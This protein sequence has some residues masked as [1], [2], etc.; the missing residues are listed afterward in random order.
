MLTVKEAIERRR[1]IRQF[2]PDPVPEEALDQILEAARL[3]PSASNRQPWRFQV[4]K[5]PALRQK[6]Y[7]EA[8]FGQR[9]LAQAPVLI[10]C[11]SE[12]HTFLKGHPLSPPGSDLGAESEDWEQLKAF[13]PDAHMN[14]AIAIENM[15][16][17]ATAL[18]LG[19]CW[20]QRIRYGQMARI[21][22][23]PRH[24]VVLSILALGYPAEAPPPR[25]RIP[26]E[27]MLVVPTL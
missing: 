11:G 21:L 19:S 14:T 24:I 2:K 25:P 9:Q 27:Q 7:E 8:S 20:T 6:L 17:M 23:W 1:S 18:G 10:V 15:M 22:G 4:I 13:L 16:L 3:A 12:L 26:R 5:D